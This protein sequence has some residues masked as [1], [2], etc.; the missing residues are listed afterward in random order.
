MCLPVWETLVQILGWEEALEKSMAA[1]SGILAW[2][3][4]CTRS[5]VGY[6]PGGSQR[7][8]HDWAAKQDRSMRY[9]LWYTPSLHWFYRNKCHCLATGM[10]ED[11]VCLFGFSFCLREPSNL[12]QCISHSLILGQAGVESVSS[13]APFLH[14]GAHFLWEWSIKLYFVVWSIKPYFQSKIH[15]KWQY[16]I[17]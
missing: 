11:F 13:W 8:R 9:R 7:V 5:L 2:A 17:F 14:L 10:K 6:S 12:P 1:H 16:P 4:P 3:S 15:L